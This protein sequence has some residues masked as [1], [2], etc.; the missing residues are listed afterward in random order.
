M[1]G[2]SREG[3]Y[4]PEPHRWREKAGGQGVTRK[5][6]G[7]G[8]RWPRNSDAV[9][10]LGTQRRGPRAG[11]TKAICMAAL[12]SRPKETKL[13]VAGGGWVAS[14]RQRAR[15]TAPGASRPLR[16]PAATLA[17]D[18]SRRGGTVMLGM[19]CV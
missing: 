9:G 7:N 17:R 1:H 2:P 6:T 8:L 5:R 3:K 18:L 16:V 4:G 12:G 10:E 14:T 13:R 15:R 11:R 19:P